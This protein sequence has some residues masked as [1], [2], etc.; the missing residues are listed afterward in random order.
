MNLLNLQTTRLIVYDKM[1]IRDRTGPS[2]LIVVDIDHLDS[3]GEA[4]KLKRQLFNDR[5]LRPVLAL[6][7]IHI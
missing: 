6:S 3:R 7:L 4:E 2:G 5:L 1:C